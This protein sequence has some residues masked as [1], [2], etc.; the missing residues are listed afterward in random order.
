[1]NLKNSLLTV[2]SCVLFH[3]AQATTDDPTDNAHYGYIENKGQI[4]DQNRNARSDIRF[5]YYDDQFKLT[6]RNTGFSYEFVK[7][8]YLQPNTTE[9]GTPKE[10]E[11]EN[12][13]EYTA[14][15]TVNR[16]DIDFVK[17]NQNM[18]VILSMCFRHLGLVVIY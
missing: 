3:I 15:Y 7:T 12:E 6:L 10:I 16:V 4:H 11:D 18:E 17:P 2:L 5:M 13:V 9:S 1:M 8:D 14:Q